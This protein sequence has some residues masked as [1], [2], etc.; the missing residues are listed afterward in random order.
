[1]ISEIDDG[2][3]NA[4]EGLEMLRRLKSLGFDHVAATPHTRPGMFDNTNPALRAAFWRMKAQI[5]T[6]GEFPEVSLASEH[7]FDEAVVTAIHSGAGLPYRRACEP[8]SSENVQIP[9]MG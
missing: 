8:A 1:W 3:R 9:R 4:D 5:P 2:A 7:F 6:S